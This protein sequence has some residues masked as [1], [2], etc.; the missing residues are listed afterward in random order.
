MITKE[1]LINRG[2]KKAMA[3]WR[4]YYVTDEISIKLWG[5]GT[6]KVYAMELKD[7]IGTANTLE[8]LE[9]LEQEVYKRLSRMYSVRAQ[10]DLALSDRYKSMIKDDNRA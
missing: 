7:E 2:Y 4:E 5:N 1:D 6:A 9:A 3:D 8:E 10:F